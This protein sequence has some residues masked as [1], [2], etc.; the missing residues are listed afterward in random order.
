MN[1]I[2]KFE[3]EKAQRIRVQAKDTQLVEAAHNFLERSIKSLYS[4]NFSW[5]G[6][7]II[8]YPQ[9]IIAM[10]EILWEVK[11]D[12]VIETGIAHG[13]SLVFYA[14][15]LELIGKGEVLGIDIKIRKHNRHEIEASP[16]FKRIIMLE[17]SSISKGVIKKV[18]KIVNGKKIVLVC[19][20]SNHAH[21]HVLREMELYSPFVTKGSYLVVFDTIV[22]DLPQK[23]FSDRS[24]DKG[25]NPKTAVF[26][27]IKKHPE[28]VID[29]NID[30]KLLIS[31]APDGYLKRI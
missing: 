22:E 10:Q 23:F 11:P 26:G 1:K 19:L 18:R 2:N 5:L 8:Q 29:K 6:R 7:P 14:S 27:F 15:M 31:V 20:D 4:Y 30:N 21:K 12:L 16:M 17:G 3:K 9:D 24:W 13:G 25:N 28:F